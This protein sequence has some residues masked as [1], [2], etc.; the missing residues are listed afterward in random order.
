ML[1]LRFP[2]LLLLFDDQQREGVDVHQRE[3]EEQQ[4]RVE[5][6]QRR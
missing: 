2:P 5:V 4:R 6:Q 3:V 1:L